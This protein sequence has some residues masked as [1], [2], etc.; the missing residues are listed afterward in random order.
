MEE[1]LFINNLVKYLWK[2]KIWIIAVAFICA[3][4]GYIYAKKTVNPEYTSS[5]T[6]KFNRDITVLPEGEGN[7]SIGDAITQGTALYDYEVYKNQGLISAYSEFLRSRQLHKQILEELEYAD[8][9]K[10]YEKF[11]DNLNIAYNTNTGII[12]VTVTAYDAEQACN[13][14]TKLNELSRSE[15]EKL[16]GTQ[17]IYT[18]NE[19]EVDTMPIKQSKI[20]YAIFFG[21]AGGVVVCFIFFL[22]YFFDKT[23]TSKEELV[24]AIDY[25]ILATIPK[26]DKDMDTSGVVA[27][28]DSSSNI[29]ENFRILRTNLEK[30]ISKNS[31]KVIF[32]TA[33]K[34]G[35]GVS[36]CASN[37]AVVCAMQG[38]KTVLVDANLRS[39]EIATLFDVD[40]KIGLSEYLAKDI[41]E[42]KIVTGTKQD[43]L[44]V[45][46]AGETPDNPSELL[47]S[48]K[49]TKLI[50]KLKGEYDLVIVDGSPLLDITDG[51]ILAGISEEVLVVTSYRET[52]KDDLELAKNAL[53]NVEANNVSTVFNK[54]VK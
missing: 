7:V 13:I 23:I 32:V 35:E 44:S 50:E 5:F 47:S 20:T 46:V 16:F 24:K 15:F 14:A 42:A 37:L 12:R 11:T 29:T 25:P 43:K 53:S 30:V 45:I 2:K 48:D 33:T 6:L 51:L 52:K 38:K 1:E 19:P 40:N 27:L 34:N 9:Y 28:N 54:F 39:G 18:I 21:I 41:D 49:M 17:E 31:H 36:T 10:D 8:K 3:V 4:V 22:R 26:F